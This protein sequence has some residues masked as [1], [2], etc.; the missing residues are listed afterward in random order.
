MSALSSADAIGAAGIAC[1]AFG[2]GLAWPPAGF[3]TLGIF[4]IAIARTEDK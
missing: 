1:L 2:A 3:V 4:L